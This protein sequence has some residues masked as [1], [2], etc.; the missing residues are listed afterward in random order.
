MTAHLQVL[1]PLPVLPSRPGPSATA[2]VPTDV[3]TATVDGA[4]ITAGQLREL[5]EQ[6][7]AICPGGLQAPTGGTLGISLVDPVTGV[8]RATVSRPEL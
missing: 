1:A 7:D 5:L 6:L 3:D 4:P 2:T 8:L